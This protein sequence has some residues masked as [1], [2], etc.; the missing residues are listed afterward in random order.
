MIDLKEIPHH[1]RVNAHAVART[2]GRLVPDLRIRAAQVVD[3][4]TR[5]L[6]QDLLTLVQLL[7]GG[8]DGSA[9]EMWASLPDN[10]GR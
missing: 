6:V 5:E 8:A 3:T 9:N 1:E 10:S 4:E 2:V 7:A